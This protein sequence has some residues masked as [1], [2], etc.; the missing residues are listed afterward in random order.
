M[1]QETVEF[2]NVFE[3]NFELDGQAFVWVGSSV[4]FEGLVAVELYGDDIL[5]GV[6]LDGCWGLAFK[7]LSSTVNEYGYWW[8]RKNKLLCRGLF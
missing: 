8:G 2:L 6:K 4:F 1:G 7:H 5:G 3:E